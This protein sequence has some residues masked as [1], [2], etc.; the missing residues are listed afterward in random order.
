M[1][2]VIVKQPIELREDDLKEIFALYTSCTRYEFDQIFDE[3]CRYYYLHEKLSDEYEVAID[4]QEYA[5]DAWRSV[6]L[7]LSR[8]GYSLMKGDEVI[9]LSNA[10]EQLLIDT[11]DKWRG[12]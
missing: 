12:E 9:D 5:I 3:G 4:K 11:G 7:F 1:S 8:R 6:L 10:A 2:K